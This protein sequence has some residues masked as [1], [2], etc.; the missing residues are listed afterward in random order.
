MK[1][2][3]SIQARLG[4]TRLPGKVLKEINGK[5]ILY[6]HID[7]IK[8]SRLIDDII[9]ATTTNPKDD[10]IVEFCKKYNFKYFR[11]SEN[12]VL[13]RITSLVKLHK[14]DIHVEFFGDS[15]L[16][17]AHIVDEFI[18]Y[19]LKN[20]NKIDFLSNSLKT[21]YP[22]G[23]EVVI[24]KGDILIKANEMVDADDPLREHVS[25]H[26]YKKPQHFKIKNLDAPNHYNYPDIFLEIDT[27]EDFKLIEIIINNFFNKNQYYFSLSQ[28][29]D[30]LNKNSDLKKI[31]NDV[32]RR[33]K[34]YRNY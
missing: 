9:V 33:W 11:G 31:N 4:S 16:S 3:A 34:K 8:N 21:T 10:K 7:R 29:L 12:D 25:L 13:D 20:I 24:Y 5:P 1:I 28:I 19:F 22:P 23:Q 6:W 2:V 18:G 27:E 30:F 15:P 26:I 17:D 14:V 32:H